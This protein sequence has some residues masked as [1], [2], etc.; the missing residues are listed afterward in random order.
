MNGID[1]NI[2]LNGKLSLNNEYKL[3]ENILEIYT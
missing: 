3:N 2:E 1:M